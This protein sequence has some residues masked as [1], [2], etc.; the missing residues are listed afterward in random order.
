MKETPTTTP[1]ASNHPLAPKQTKE[2]FMNPKFTSKQTNSPRKNKNAEQYDN[3]DDNESLKIKSSNP[4]AR[5]RSHIYHS[6]DP[7][8]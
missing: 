8:P 7:D 6:G 4:R 1:A 5:A 2:K 3:D